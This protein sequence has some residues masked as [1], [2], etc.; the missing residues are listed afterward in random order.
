[1]DESLT[2]EDSLPHH[3]RAWSQHDLL[4]SILS[5]YVH[6]LSENGGRWPSWCIMPMEGED[7]HE[8][9]STINKHLERLGWMTKLTRDDDWVL[10]V[11]PA[12]E[13][14]FPRLNNVL[15]FW[16]LSLL[17]LTL[18]GDVWMQS[19]RP[20]G[21]W[22]HASSFVDALVGYTLPIVAV[23]LLASF[24][25]RRIARRFGVRSGHIMP[26]P[27]FTI[28][29]YALG[30][31]PAEWLFW[32]FGILLIP[33]MPRMD[34][35]PW[36]NRAALGHTALSVPLVLA[37]AGIILLMLGIG[38][39]PEYLESTTMPLI[40]VSPVFLS[41]IATEF[42]AEDA[43]I[44]MAWAHPWVHAGGMLILFSWISLLPI[45]TFPGGRLLIAR[46]GLFDARSSSTQSLLFVT[47]LLFAY[48]FDVFA[49]FSLW[50]LVL[51]LLLPLLFF[52]GNDIR[53][54]L[55]LDET[56][57]L[58]EEDH[59]KMGM[60]LL[61][62]FLFLL[63]AQ[64]PV[65]HDESWDA[66]M[67]Y[68][69]LSPELAVVD[70]NMTWTSHNEVRITNPSSL[71]QPYAI[72]ALF[73]QE[74]TNWE[75]EWDC[76]GESTRQFNGFGCGSDL[77]PQRTAVFWVNLT[78]SGP[79]APTAANFSYVVEMNDDYYVEPMQVRPALEV[80]PSETW[81]DVESGD[82]VLRCVDLYG[83][84]IQSDEL[85]ISVMESQLE[86][87]QTTLVQIDNEIG[88]NASYLETPDVFCLRGLDPLVFEPSM[89]TL[90]INNDTFEP[91]LPAQ[92]P[93]VAYVPEEG[94]VITG[95]HS[96]SWG[97]LLSEGGVLLEN[98]AFCP[99]NASV[100]PP[101]RPSDGAWVWDTSIRSVGSLPVI[102]GDQNLTLHVEN[103]A[104]ITVCD[105]T[106]SPYPRLNFTVMEGPELLVTW[107]NSTT[108]FW[109]T[110]WAIAYEGTFINGGMDSITFH[111]PTNESIPFRLAREGGFGD[112]WTHDWDGSSLAPGST[113]LTL[114][115]PQ[116]PLATMWVTYD[117][118]TVV[119]H[120]ASYP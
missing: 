38:L 65:L 35:R 107:M 13:R 31:F 18:A 117:S 86:G 111:N 79:L 119:L 104:N 48:L 83:D 46:M 63:P 26:V 29:L 58:S 116:E 113:P 81:Y 54:P 80:V 92:G 114:S 71:R 73:E 47:I 14:Q 36:P 97:A 75:V 5:T 61:I 105:D 109:T 74:R 88:M 55:I 17:T 22:F 6:I 42:I 51:A 72:H 67:S 27:D 93:R 12:P 4:E 57:G 110:P 15:L 62:I 82:A 53:I 103:G 30:L 68:T 101:A 43:M 115:P 39:T 99:I 16:M 120:L 37:V 56:S 21:G 8:E 108:R 3:K 44:R 11:F 23:L 87:L 1:M 85:N 59:R 64:Q 70:D 52:F 96:Q 112:D 40:T 10:T 89:A 118:G 34:A 106:F 78:W 41:L 102:D 28:A 2:V 66:E 94:W 90:H 77:L 9:L 32:P 95:N 76:D 60:L 49:G 33:T 45:P 91:L 98:E 25:Q 84:I 69:L 7:I 100:S 24:L 19:V 20:E 50:Y